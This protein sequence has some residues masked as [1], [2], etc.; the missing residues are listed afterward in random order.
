MARTA[1]SPAM[2]V[3]EAIAADLGVDPSELDTPLYAAVDPDALDRLL[4]SDGV[5]LAFE[6][7]GHTVVVEGGDTVDVRVEAAGQGGPG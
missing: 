1:P 5:V 3:L 4:S 7:D 2:A 6:Y